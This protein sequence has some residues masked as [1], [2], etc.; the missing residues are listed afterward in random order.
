MRVC[1]AQIKPDKG[2]IQNNI[3]IHKKWIQIAVSEKTDLIVFPELSLTGYEP[4]L[5]KQLATDQNDARLNEFQE[6]SN[7]YKI[8]I[9]IGLPIKAKLGTLIGMV[10]FEPNRPKQT[11]SK[12]KLHSDELVYFIEGKDQLILNIKST[13]I[14]PAICYESVQLSHFENA[15]NLGADIYLASV[16]KSQTGIENASVHFSEIASKYTTPILMSNCIGV[17]DNFQALGQS[18]IWD[19]KGVLLEK[20]GTTTEGILIFDTDTEEVLRKENK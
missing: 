14:A 15:K 18:A 6:I 19:S 2:N 16:A 8:S 10:I 7:L 9:A 17:C 5:A 1:I 11:Y 12:Q 20:L 4:D 13:K 3:E